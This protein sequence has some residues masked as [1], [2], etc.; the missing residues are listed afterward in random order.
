VIV[1]WHSLEH[2]SDPGALL[3]AAAGNLRPGGVLV[4]AV[5]N[6][7]AL[8]F[9]VLGRRWPHIDA[10]RHLHLMPAG[11]VTARAERHGLQ[12]VSLTS[13]DGGARHWNAFGWGRGVLPPNPGKLLSHGAIHLG[14]ALAFVAAPAEHRPGRGSAYTISL[15]KR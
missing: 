12:R 11:A 13:D 1:L 3:Q 6:P 7:Q 2:L 9:R 14:R 10:P 8:Q 4:A 5:P 15:R